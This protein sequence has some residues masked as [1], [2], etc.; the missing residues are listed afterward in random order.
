M[1]IEKEFAK[2]KSYYMYFYFVGVSE[3]KDINGRKFSHTQHGGSGLMFT[4]NE[5]APGEMG[6]SD[7]R[8]PGEIYCQVN[9]ETF[10]NGQ[11]AGVLINILKTNFTAF[12]SVSVY[13]D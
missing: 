6:S 12:N 1:N 9:P 10:N 5:G 13:F 3:N 11:S 4:V 8:L 2:I 7:G